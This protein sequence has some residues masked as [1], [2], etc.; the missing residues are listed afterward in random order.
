MDEI[1]RVYWH[2]LH[3]FF[4]PS[5]RLL[6]KKRV[7]DKVVKIHDKPTTPYDRLM[8]RSQLSKEQK[9]RL[10]LQKTH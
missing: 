9:E 5:Y 4:L 7:G 3:D 10:T 8:A 2:P 1:Y 6:D